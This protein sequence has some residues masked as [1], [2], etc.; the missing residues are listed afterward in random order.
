MT[1]AIVQSQ[2]ITQTPADNYANSF[3]NNVVAGNSVILIADAAASSAAMS[4]SA[5]KFNGSSVTGAAQIFS[6]SSGSSGNNV[7]S[8]AWLLPN[9]SGGAKSVGLTM[10]GAANFGTGA[11]G[12]WG[13]EV[14]GLGAS[15]TIIS[16]TATAAATSGTSAASGTT[17][18]ATADGLAIGLIAFFGV[19]VTA[20]GSPWTHMAAMTDNFGVAAYD[21][22]SSGSTVAFTA[23]ATSAA[24]A[25]G[26]AIIVPTATAVNSALMAAGFI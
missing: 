9:V 17:G 20:E 23:T 7:Y 11:T 14:S 26:A 22:I 19:S 12:L 24:W 1:V 5:P 8:T 18:A 16:P 4:S 6:I 21:L 15:P 3:T 2:I 13:L 10:T 25:A